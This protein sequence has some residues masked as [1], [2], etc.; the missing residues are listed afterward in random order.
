MKLRKHSHYSSTFAS[1]DARTST[2]HV[3]LSRHAIKI[4]LRDFFSAHKFNHHLQP[5]LPFFYVISDGS[6]RTNLTIL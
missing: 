3:V 4:R 2:A 1:P 5:V 6:T